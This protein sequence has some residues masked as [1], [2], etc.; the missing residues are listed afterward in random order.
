MKSVLA[1]VVALASFLTYAADLGGAGANERVLIARVPGDGV[2]PEVAI[3][4][5]GAVHLVYLAGSPAAANVFYARSEDGGGTFSTPVRVNSQPGSA[6]ATGTIRGA[7]LAVG[8][9]GRIHVVWNGSATA[10]PRPATSPSAPLLYSRSGP[11][12][13]A[14]EP[15]RNLVSRTTNLD[16]GASLAADEQ[17]VYVAWHG[18]AAEGEQAERARRV[19]LR[20]SR[21]DGATF[22]PEMAVSDSAVGACAC[23]A[24]RAMSA[25]GPELHL[26]FRA[27]L[28]GTHRDVHSLLSRDRGR[29]FRENRLHP[30]E[31]PTCPMTSMSI[32][33]GAGRVLHAWETAGE[34]Y[35]A[36]AVAAGAPVAPPRSKNV[37]PPR[38]HPRL[39][40]AR[41][42]SLLLVWTEGTSWSRG[43]SV[44]WQVFGPDHR[45][46]TAAGVLPGLPAWSF[47][48]GIA[49]PDGSF[50]ILY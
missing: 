50:R 37:Q 30:W 1:L 44:A 18:N 29:T 31:S 48:A 21:D 20:T 26:L 8:R 43:G 28:Q 6:I 23:C 10:T 11:G 4:R 35:F 22:E 27:A 15:Q 7:Y 46:T 16:G 2:Q 42:G 3:D 24:L 12:D 38:K 39:S 36:P 47:A 40:V 49:L 33:A 13:T 32:A 9:D 45:P 19:W 17:G 41:D 25:P 14:F 34:V 5:E